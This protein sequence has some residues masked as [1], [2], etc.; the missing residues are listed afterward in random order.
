MMLPLISCEG[1]RRKQ[2]EIELAITDFKTAAD[3]FL[4]HK[5][6]ESAR[7]CLAHIK[8]IQP[9]NQAVP[10]PICT[11]RDFVK[12]VLDTAQQGD[13]HQ[14]LDE[15]N[16]VLKADPTDSQAYCCRGIIHCKQHH[17]QQ[18]LLDF[19]QALQLG[20]AATIVYRNRSKARLQLGD[21]QGAITDSNLAL[22]MDDQ[23]PHNYLTRGNAYGA[24]GHALGAIEDYT[25]AL[26]LNPN[27]ASAYYQRGLIY[28]AMEERLQ[29]LSDYQRAMSLWC[30]Q[31]DWTHY[32]A[33]LA[34]FKSIQHSPQL[35]LA[36][37][38]YE[39]LHL[40]L[41][42]LVGGQWPIA[43]G[44]IKR[45]KINYPGRSEQWYLETV[46]QELES[47]LELE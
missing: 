2:G 23:D 35:E 9:R 30:E 29:A 39:R 25:A 16:W 34:S 32:Q 42:D 22:S 3:L 26:H 45:M 47:N 8:Q 28:A 33:V 38:S 15:I 13:I 44:M 12:R 36:Q 20:Y 1:V 46:I 17:Y 11:E 4:T 31:G 43:E 10:A 40:R 7:Q 18:A 37:T 19:N 27:Q 21:Y 14:A 24:I 41:L 5:N 6:A